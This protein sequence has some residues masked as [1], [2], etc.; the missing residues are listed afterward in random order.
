MGGEEKC[1]E[2]TIRKPIAAYRLVMGGDP[3]WVPGSGPPLS[4]SVGGPYARGP[5]TLFGFELE[6]SMFIL[7]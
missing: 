7:I 4:G 3:V 2:N 1:V 6:F 5:P